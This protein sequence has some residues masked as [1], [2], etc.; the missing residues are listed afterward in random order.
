MLIVQDGRNKESLL[1]RLPGKALVAPTAA[2]RDQPAKPLF[3]LRG[4]RRS[5]V[6]WGPWRT[7]NRH[8]NPWT[9]PN[10]LSMMSIGLDLFWGY[11]II[12]EDFNV[13]LRGL[14]SFD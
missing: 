7:A 11:L 6:G 1:P 14:L 9:I 8:Q 4:G 13:A 2:A 5:P 10:M 3:P 12:K